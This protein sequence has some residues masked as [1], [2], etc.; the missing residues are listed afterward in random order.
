MTTGT[1]HNNTNN[2]YKSQTSSPKTQRSLLKSYGNPDLGL[3]HM[4][5]RV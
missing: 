3:I 4:C 2:S 1:I 5:G